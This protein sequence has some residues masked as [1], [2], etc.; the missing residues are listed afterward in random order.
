MKKICLY[1][2]LAIAL[3]LTGCGG[4]QKGP[5]FQTTD[6]VGTWWAPSQAL[7]AG[8][9]D[10]IV[11]VFSNAAAVINN[12]NAGYWGYTYD[13]GDDV[14]ANDVLTDQEKGGSY[15]G[16][17]WMGW[18]LSPKAIETLQ[19]QNTAPGLTVPTFPKSLNYSVIS[20]T[21][22]RLVDAGKTY[23]LRKAS[24]Q[25]DITMREIEIQTPKR[26][27]KH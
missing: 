26:C 16:N 22:I 10:S 17:G 1:L 4:M 27:K 19:T 21:E 24:N 6:L 7:E 5:D 3:S 2:S 11:F 20:K 23:L 9:K 15:H 18:T 14:T 13:T 12:E 8:N 25:A